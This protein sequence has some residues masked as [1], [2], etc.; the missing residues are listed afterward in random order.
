MFSIAQ[1][2]LPLHPFTVH[3]PLA[4]LLAHALFTLL[5]LW[6]RTPSLETSAYH[7]LI[8]GWFG[9]VLATLTGSLDAW[10]QIYSGSAG[11]TTDLALLNR[12]NAHAAS[13]LAIVIVYGNLLLRRRRLPTLLDD[14]VQRRG[15]LRLLAVGVLLLLLGGWLGGQ[16]VYRFGLGVQA[17]A[18]PGPYGCWRSLHM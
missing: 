14:P 18:L 12:V 11:A 13:G 7:C 16:L 15:Y 6:R 9:A 4:L 5:Y 3:V 2:I 1:T 10:Q 17:V 8:V